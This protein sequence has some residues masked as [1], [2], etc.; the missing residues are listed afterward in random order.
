MRSWTVMLNG[1]KKIINGLNLL[2]PEKIIEIS[3]KD[4]N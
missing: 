3:L 4:L 1:K 2:I